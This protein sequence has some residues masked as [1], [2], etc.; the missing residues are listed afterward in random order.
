MTSHDHDMFLSSA[1]VNCAHTHIY[2]Q[3]T[4]VPHLCALDANTPEG[5]QTHTNT[6]LPT[7]L[8]VNLWLTPARSSCYGW[9]SSVLT[10]QQKHTWIQS[11]SSY[12]QTY[13]HLQTSGAVQ[14]EPSGSHAQRTHTH[15][16]N[17]IIINKPS[18][19]HDHKQTHIH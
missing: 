19:I 3:R 11:Q 18:H 7:Q 16:H 2:R 17:L 10:L 5:V 4:A 6:R 15:F 13:T 9:M 12:T 14:S 1:A 8:S